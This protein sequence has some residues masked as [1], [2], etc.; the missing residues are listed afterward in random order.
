MMRIRRHYG[1]NEQLEKIPGL[2]EHIKEQSI[3]LNATALA[4]LQNERT[5]WVKGT[6]SDETDIVAS[7]IS[8]MVELQDRIIALVHVLAEIRKKSEENGDEQYEFHDLKMVGLELEYMCSIMSR[9]REVTEYP[10]SVFWMERR[11]SREAEQQVVFIISPLSIASMMQEALFDRY[12]TVVCTSATLT[13]KDRFSFWM[14]QIGLDRVEEERVESVLLQSPFPYRQNVLLAVPADAPPPDN[15]LYPRYLCRVVGEVLSVS[16]GRGLVLF[17]SYALLNTV[18]KEVQPVLRTRGITTLKQGEVDRAKL[19]RDFTCDVASVLFATASF[20][21]GIDA[22]GETLKIVI[23]TRLPFKVPTGPV[24]RARMEAIEKSGGNPFFQLALPEA[25]MKF[26]QGFGRLMRRQ[27]DHGIV[28]VLDS[29]IISK[30][31]GQTFLQSLPETVQSIKAGEFIIEEI[32]NFLY[33][34][35]V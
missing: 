24:F 12:G 30:S 29:R 28:L 5:V 15:E 22:P 9:F 25:V 4:L 17:T 23:I 3:T 19:L 35:P 7:V 2:L 33:P 14:K 11:G 18:Y 32:E 26:K 1:S 13:V 31:Y 34:A 10:E 21:E 20:W 6:E 27:T 8:E 16:E